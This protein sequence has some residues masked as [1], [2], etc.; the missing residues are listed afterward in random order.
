MKIRIV[1]AAISE[2]IRI[3]SS[4]SRMRS[5]SPPQAPG[6]Q[7]R[8]PYG[9]WHRRRP[10]PTTSAPVQIKKASRRDTAA[11]ARRLALVAGAAG[12]LDE[13][14]DQG[15]TDPAGDILVNR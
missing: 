12:F 1:A 7:A 8:P 3:S 15:L 6:D 10:V 4:R 2:V 14:V 9:R 13:L 11:K 5:I